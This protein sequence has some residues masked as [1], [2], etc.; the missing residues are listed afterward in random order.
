MNPWWKQRLDSGALLRKFQL[1][2]F[3]PLPQGRKPAETSLYAEHDRRS[4]GV[5]PVL[6]RVPAP[7]PA[8]DLQITCKGSVEW[9]K[10]QSKDSCVCIYMYVCVTAPGVTQGCR[11]LQLWSTILSENELSPKGGSVQWCR[12]AGTL[13]WCHPALFQKARIEGGT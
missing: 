4:N 1:V 10:P 5:G 8:A 7:P 3:F 11:S 13:R 9:R 12:G 2:L 6:L